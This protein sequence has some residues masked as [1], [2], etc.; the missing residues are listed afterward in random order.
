VDTAGVDPVVK[1]NIIILGWFES[2]ARV[3]ILQINTFS[4]PLAHT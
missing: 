1:F 4:P 2:E 3:A